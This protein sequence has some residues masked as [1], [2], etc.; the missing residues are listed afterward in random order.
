MSVAYKQNNYRTLGNGVVLSDHHGQDYVPKTHIC[1]Q[2]LRLRAAQISE[3]FDGAIGSPLIEGIRYA[4]I[5]ELD[6]CVHQL[7]SWREIAAMVK[8]RTDHFYS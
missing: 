4:M 7:G 6:A 2:I 3:A 1:Q 8:G 5:A